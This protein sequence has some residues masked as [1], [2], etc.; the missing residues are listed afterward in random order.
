VHDRR[1]R[2]RGSRSESVDEHP[3]RR[4]LGDGSG[5]PVQPDGR[6]VRRIGEHE[7]LFE[8]SA[9]AVPEQRPNQFRS[10][11]PPA[12][13]LRDLDLVEEHLPSLGLELPQPGA[14]E[15]ADRRPSLGR[16]QEDVVGVREVCADGSRIGRLVEERG[17]SEYLGF[18]PGA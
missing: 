15:E 16:E 2:C 11:A 8:S 1:A 6:L 14:T 9:A 10:D 3:V 4:S 12:E 7:H 17:G 13:P 18:V 5:G